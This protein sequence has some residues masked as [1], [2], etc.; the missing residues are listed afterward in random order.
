[1]SLF[2]NLVSTDETTKSDL[3]FRELPIFSY[4]NLVDKEEIGVGA[5][6]VV[7][8]AKLP[9]KSKVVVKKLI[10]G[11]EES[12]KSL[13]KEARLLQNLRH[14]NVVEFKGICTDQLSLLL[15]YAYFDFNPFG[16]DI[17]T[18]SL[19]EFLAVCEQSSCDGM[20]VAVFTHA[21]FDVASGLKYLHQNNI[22]HR[23]LKP[24]NILV[25]NR[26]YHHLSDQ[27]KIKQIISI[28]PLVCKLADFGES[29][30]TD[31]QTQNIL[32]SRTNRV[33]RG[34]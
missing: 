31:I 13:V 15:E 4:K 24:A 21:A 9:D 25:S 14:A 22:A 11:D 20:N 10:S 3:D 26:H 17:Q 30:S 27:E 7:F 6:A 23:D 28:K 19:A 33:D 12:K 1:M 29:R 16:C 18:H 2:G 5:F 8:T 32:K 34:K